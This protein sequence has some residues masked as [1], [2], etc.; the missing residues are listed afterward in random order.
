MGDPA[1]IGPEIAVKA[2][3]TERLFEV[4]RPVIIGDA[5]VFEDIVKRFGSKA[6]INAITDIRTPNLFTASPMFT[7]CKM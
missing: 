4:C 3:L 5:A 1:S 2:L 7:I 6:K